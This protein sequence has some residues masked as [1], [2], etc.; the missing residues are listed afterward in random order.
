MMCLKVF[1]RKHSC[2]SRNYLGIFLEGLRKT[3]VRTLI[4]PDE[5]KTEHLLNTNLKCYL[6]AI[7]S[8]KLVGVSSSGTTSISSLVRIGQLMGKFKEHTHTHTQTD[9]NKNLPFI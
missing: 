2:Q 7:C 4:I 8:M 1:G 9:D 6:E 5:I 3:S